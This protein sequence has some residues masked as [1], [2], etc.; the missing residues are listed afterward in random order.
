MSYLELNRASLWP[1]FAFMA[2]P[3]QSARHN[4]MELN[5]VK[6]EWDVSRAKRRQA[7]G[8]TTA[9]HKQ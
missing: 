3:A 6:S 9:N 7:L 1:S 5:T 8:L 2:L 4:E